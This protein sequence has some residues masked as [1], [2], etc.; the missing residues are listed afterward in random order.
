MP[1]Q[2]RPTSKGQ[3]KRKERGEALMTDASSAYA[4]V[5][6]VR[7]TQEE[8]IFQFGQRSVNNPEQADGIINIITSLPHAKRILKVLAGSIERYEAVFGEIPED[9]VQNLSPEILDHLKRTGQIH[10]E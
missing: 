10:D 1:Q 2:K 3:E 5:C 9:P 7:A 8:F 6:N 4:D